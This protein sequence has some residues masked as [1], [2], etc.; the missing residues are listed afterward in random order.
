MISNLKSIEE[1][2]EYL[3]SVIGIRGKFIDWKNSIGKEIKY[4]Y[5]WYNDEY[6]K[7]FI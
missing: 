3:K 2:K 7:G 5:Y 6:S 1:N 4:E